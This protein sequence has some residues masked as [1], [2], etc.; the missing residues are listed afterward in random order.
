MADK[1][2]GTFLKKSEIKSPTNTFSVQEFYL[3]CSY[4]NEYQE[5][6]TNILKFQVTNDK[7]QLLNNVVKG[8]KIEVEYFTKG[9]FYDKKDTSGNPT[10]EKVHAQNLNVKSVVKINNNYQ[11]QPQQ[12][13][14]Q[15]QQYSEPVNTN[16]TED[17]EDDL[18]F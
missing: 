2:R 18:P 15:Q 8:D 9:G 11:S 10:G 7:I 17:E 14:P 1:R 12:Q 16:S 13:Q 4:T 6:F 3:D 5:T